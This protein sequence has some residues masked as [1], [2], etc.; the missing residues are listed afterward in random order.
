MGLI[1]S[2]VTL[3]FPMIPWQGWRLHCRPP[4]RQ[5]PHRM[6]LARSLAYIHRISLAR[7]PLRTLSSGGLR[8]APTIERG[9]PAPRRLAA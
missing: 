9:P 6:P 8:I 1:P 3:W 5:L 7:T 4:A 2:A